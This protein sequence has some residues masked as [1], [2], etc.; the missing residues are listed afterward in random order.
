M[1]Q[2]LTLAVI[3]LLPWTAYA[4]SVENVRFTV[5]E[6]DKFVITYDLNGSGD[7]AVTLSVSQDGGQEFGIKP[8]SVSG[9]VGDRVPAGKGKR[10]V[11]DVFKDLQRLQGDIAFL[12]TADQKGFSPGAKSSGAIA[13]MVFVQ[14]PGG[15][16]NMGSNDGE[17]DEKPV[18]RVTIQPFKMQTTEVTQAQ[19]KAVM[20]NNPSNWKGDNLPV[21]TVSW[22]YCQSFITKLNSLDPGKGYRLPTEAEWEYA[23]R[24][25]TTTKYSTGDREADLARAGWYR[26]NSDS[27][28]HPVGEK[29]PNGWGLYDMHGNVW[30]WCQDWYHDSY[31]GAPTDG[32]S[33]DRPSGTYRALRGGSWYFIDI[34]CRSADRNWNN[35]DFRGNYYGFRLVCRYEPHSASGSSLA[36]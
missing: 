35:P 18:H 20:G 19:W 24:A 4:D 23:C 14:I 6:D 32:S 21:E 34:V 30:E 22:D 36:P 15:S 2:L 25:G 12:V 27:K 10:V 11:W 28:T 1:R 3:L 29:A 5:T 33:W 26:G 17:S 7:C 9:D 8:R 31:S 13:G 16:F